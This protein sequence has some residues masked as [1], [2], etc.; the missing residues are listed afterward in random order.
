[1]VWLPIVLAMPLVFLGKLVAGIEDDDT[2]DYW[3]IAIAAVGGRFAGYLLFMLLASKLTSSG[4]LTSDVLLYFGLGVLI[5]APTVML[6]TKR[7]VSC[8]WRQAF[9]LSAVV[10]L[11]TATAECIA[12]IMYDSTSA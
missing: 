11:L 4:S 6:A 9:I 1:M 8:T 2:R 10:A 7:M 12:S 5:Q 3:N